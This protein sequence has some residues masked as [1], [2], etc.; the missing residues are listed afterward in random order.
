MWRKDK[1]KK[2]YAKLVWKRNE[3]KIRLWSRRKRR[4]P[5]KIGKNKMEKNK[6]NKT[7]TLWNE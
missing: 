7:T 4:N 6:I 2:T 5:G 1:E 3:M